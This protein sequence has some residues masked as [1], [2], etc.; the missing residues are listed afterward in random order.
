MPLPLLGPQ[1]LVVDTMVLYDDIVRRLRHNQP[2]TA[3]IESVNRRAT[4]LFAASHVYE[5]MYDHIGGFQRRAV[6]RSE[7]LRVFEEVYLRACRFVETPQGELHPRV[8]P[9]AEADA[10]DV[11]RRNSHCCSPLATFSRATPTCST[12]DSARATG[13]R[14]CS[15]PKNCSVSTARPSQ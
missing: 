1:V 7:V 2:R 10:S 13:L 8:L 5:E 6:E 15:R 4:R 9:V 11:P 14:E 3:L 12:P